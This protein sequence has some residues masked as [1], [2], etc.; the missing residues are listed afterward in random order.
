MLQQARE[1]LLARLEV[2]HLPT[3]EAVTGIRNQWNAE[4][5]IAPLSSCSVISMHHSSRFYIAYDM[6]LCNLRV[7]LFPSPT[8][9]SQAR[10]RKSRLLKYRR[11]SQCEKCKMTNRMRLLHKKEIVAR[12]NG[13]RISGW[14][15][16]YDC[17][18]SLVFFA[19]WICWIYSS[20][21]TCNK[22]W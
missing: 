1:G 15:L 21:K 11:K 18:A 20:W 9:V 16:T 22:L 2:A 3:S 8:F 13:R 6:T 4:P 14:R 7:P 10:W 19:V 12:K 17:A 5:R